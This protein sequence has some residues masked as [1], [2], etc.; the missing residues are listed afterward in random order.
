MKAK[1]IFSLLLLIICLLIPFEP[2]SRWVAESSTPVY[3]TQPCI[4]WG[5]WTVGQSSGSGNTVVTTFITNSEKTACVKINVKYCASQPSAYV[6]PIESFDFQITMNNGFTVRKQVEATR[7]PAASQFS[8]NTTFSVEAMLEGPADTASVRSCNNLNGRNNTAMAVTITFKG[9]YGSDAENLKTVTLTKTWTQDTVDMLRQEYVDMTPPDGRAELPVP[10]RGQFKSEISSNGVDDWN[11]GHYSYM[12]DVGLKAKKSSWLTQVNNYRTANNLPVFA[13]RQF[14]VNSAYRNPY[15][16]RFHVAAPN[17]ASFHS[18]HCYGDALDVR[19][20]D[21]DSDST[22]EQVVGN[23]AKSDDGVLMELRAVDAGAKWTAS[24]EYYPTHTHADWTSRS[25]W[26]PPKGTVY[27]PPCEMPDDTT[28]SST[29]S[30]NSGDSG[31]G[32]SGNGN[33]GNSETLH[34]CNVHTISTSG[35]HSLQASCST[36]GCIS[37]NFYQCQHE[38]HTYRSIAGACG[39]T[40]PS[41][42][43]LSHREVAFPCRS[44]LY[45]VCSEPST[46]ETRRHHR[47]MLPCGEHLGRLCAASSYHTQSVSCPQ[48]NGVSCSSGTY[49]QCSSHTH[50]YPSSNNNNDGN[51]GDG[52]SGNSAICSA[53]HTYNP[54]NSSLVNRH[55]VRTCMRPACGQS[56]QLCSGGKPSSCGASSSWRCRE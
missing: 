17:V 14:K 2:V 32:N 3:Q 50:S 23:K 46:S 38:T 33:S 55:R 28:T 51:S 34:A 25:S 43:S 47:K 21:V 42:E 52:N 41:N 12:I 37:T 1:H 9:Y 44:H 19:T 10:G 49:Y 13:D 18:R 6:Y 39:H 24:W 54:N 56:W 45:Y 35:D 16:Q 11:T 20:I 4:R 26:P 22:V 5:D 40:Y 29:N 15:H 36:S 8:S 7:G 27:S 31:N 30:G 48:E 53:G